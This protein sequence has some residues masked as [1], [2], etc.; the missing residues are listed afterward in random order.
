MAKTRVTLT[1]TRVTWTTVTVESFYA[2]NRCRIKFQCE[3]LVYDRTYNS[4]DCSYPH[5]FLIKSVIKQIF[6]LTRSGMKQS[7]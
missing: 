1:M 2:F 6:R 4:I 3:N 7:M 5:I